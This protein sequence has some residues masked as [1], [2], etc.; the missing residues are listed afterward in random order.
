MKTAEATENL[1]CRLAADDKLRERK[2]IA[3]P[4]PVL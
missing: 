4:D 3:M 1:K 2:K